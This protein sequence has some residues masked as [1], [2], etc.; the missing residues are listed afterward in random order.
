MAAKTS[1]HRYETKLRHCHPVYTLRLL[2]ISVFRRLARA[3]KKKV[4][5]NNHDIIT[6]RFVVS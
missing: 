4:Y 3:L 1:W 2:D 6:V 5:F